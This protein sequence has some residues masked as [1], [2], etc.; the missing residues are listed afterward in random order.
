M[1]KPSISPGILLVSLISFIILA[2]QA[3]CTAQRP[4]SPQGTQRYQIHGRVESVD[5]EKQRITIAHE[6]IDGYMDAMTMPF[7]VRDP[8]IMRGFKSGDRVEA[9]LVVDNDR[10]MKWVEE[11]KPKR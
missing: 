10:N 5:F 8:E 11:I 6:K 9:R 7:A 3:S 1:R 4:P 2:T